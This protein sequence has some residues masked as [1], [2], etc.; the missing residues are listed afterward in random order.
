MR[1][2]TCLAEDKRQRSRNK[3]WITFG[4]TNDAV[5]WYCVFS[6]INTTK[7][8]AF[9]FL[10]KH[11]TY[12]LCVD[13]VPFLSIYLFCANLIWIF[14][15]EQILWTNLW[16][17]CFWSGTRCG[18]IVLEALDSSAEICVAFPYSAKLYNFCHPTTITWRRVSWNCFL[19]A[20]LQQIMKNWS[21]IWRQTFPNVGRRFCSLLRIFFVLPTTVQWFI[22]RNDDGANTQKAREIRKQEIVLLETSWRIWYLLCT[23]SLRSCL[24]NRLR[25]H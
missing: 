12:G 8:F 13:F 22:K 17:D 2:G 16:S 23:F 18:R 5:W 15:C 10:F 9:I 25:E 24:R 14:V 4:N 11:S 20:P 21:P 6:P 3:E 19:F 1:G 7:Q